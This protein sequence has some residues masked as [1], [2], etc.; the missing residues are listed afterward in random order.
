MYTVYVYSHHGF[1]CCV[2]RTLSASLAMSKAA[3]SISDAWIVSIYRDNE[4]KPFFKHT[5]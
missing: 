3:E 4:E 2:L 1:G 5:N